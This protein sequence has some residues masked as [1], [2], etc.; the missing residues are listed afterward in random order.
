MLDALLMLASNITGLW[1]SG[2]L[3]LIDMLYK[4][5]IHFHT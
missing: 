3:V 5:Y 1:I 2:A 4:Q